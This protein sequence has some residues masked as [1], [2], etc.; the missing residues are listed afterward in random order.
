MF[1]VGPAKAKVDCLQFTK[2]IFQS[3]DDLT[4][5]STWTSL[6][7]TR[8][9][10][11]GNILFKTF[12]MSK[13]LKLVQFQYKFLMRITTCRYIRH[14]MKID[15][16]NNCR[17]CSDKYTND[18]D[19]VLETLNHLFLECPTS[20][21]FFSKITS[22]IVDNFDPGYQDNRNYFLVTCDT[23]N[24]VVNYIVL[25]SKYY[26]SRSYQM[27]TPISWNSFLRTLRKMLLGERA[28]IRDVVL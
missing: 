7:G 20:S 26:I 1:Y 15:A 17:L 4:P 6:V 21:T 5:L 25:I 19:K 11:W 9:I 10:D 27:N 24:E 28:T 8:S 16:D 18:S 3:P 13:N 12:N 14:K 2:T 22:F 23:P